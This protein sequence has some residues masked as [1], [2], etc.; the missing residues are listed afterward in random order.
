MKCAAE[1]FSQHAVFSFSLRGVV[2]VL[3]LNSPPSEP[4]SASLLAMR[5][6]CDRICAFERKL[7]VLYLLEFLTP[8]RRA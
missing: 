6:S 7:G 8:Q 3:Y 1:E 2:L 5:V 4:G